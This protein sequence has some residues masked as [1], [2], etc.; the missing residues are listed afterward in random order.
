VDA[1]LHLALCSLLALGV[2]LCGCEAPAAPTDQVEEGVVAGTN[3]RYACVTT[4]EPGCNFDIGIGKSLFGAG[5]CKSGVDFE[6][7]SR[8]ASP[9]LPIVFAIHGGGIEDGTAQF[10]GYVADQLGWDFYA[11]AAHRTSASCKQTQWMH[12]TSGRFNSATA[13]AL[14][15]SHPSAVSLHGY[16]ENNPG[17]ARWP[18]DRY[19]VCVGGANAAARAAFSASLDQPACDVDGRRVDAYD[20][21]K[22]GNATGAVCGGL[23]GTSSGNVVNLPPGDG[24]QLELP[25]HLRARLAGLDGLAVDATLRARLVQAIDDAL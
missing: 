8:D 16:D 4:S 24:I 1:K 7:S 3:D 20:D 14:A 21:T 19:F 12:V 15:F 9:A 5:E 10:A 23:E 6:V 22:S 17:R 2:G 11:F 18:Q 25:R 13:R